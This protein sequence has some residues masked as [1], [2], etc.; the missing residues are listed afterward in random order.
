MLD[1]GAGD[2]RV[3]GDRGGDQMRGGAGDDVLEWNDGDGSDMRDR[4][5]RCSTWC[6]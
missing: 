5:R 6:A 1:G 2:D 3:T 4:R